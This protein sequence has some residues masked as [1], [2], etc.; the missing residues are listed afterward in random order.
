MDLYGRAYATPARHTYTPHSN[1]L[2]QRKEGTVVACFER[3][4]IHIHRST[5]SESNR[6]NP[7]SER[8]CT[9]MDSS[10]LRCGS[11]SVRGTSRRVQVPR[12]S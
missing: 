9:C 6:P 4:Q 8:C 11:Q 1:T 5:L 10:A 12:D 2:S 3:H 7:R